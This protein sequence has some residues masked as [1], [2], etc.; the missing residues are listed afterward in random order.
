M[1]VSARFAYRVHII[2]RSGHKGCKRV[3]KILEHLASGLKLLRLSGWP[4]IYLALHGIAAFATVCTRMHMYTRGNEP[5]I[6][7]HKGAFA[8]GE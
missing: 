8:I 7:K 4:R 1:I 3:Q 6:N 5:R 2:T